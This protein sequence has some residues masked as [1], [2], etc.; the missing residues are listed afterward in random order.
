[1]SHCYNKHTDLRS[2]P[3]CR[4]SHT[5][6]GCMLLVAGTTLDAQAR[7]QAGTLE[8]LNQWLAGKPFKDDNYIVRE[9][10]L[11]EQYT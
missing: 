3:L 9:G 7:Y 8:M 11:A 5:N 6:S 2:Y 4:R 1:M 10:K